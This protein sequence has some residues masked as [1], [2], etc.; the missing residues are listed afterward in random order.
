MESNPDYASS[1]TT[2]FST[3]SSGL[4]PTPHNYR[5]ISEL[6]SESWGS[7]WLT[8]FNVDQEEAQYPHQLHPPQP[9]PY[10]GKVTWSR[11]ERQ[12][13]L[14]E[15]HPVNGCC[16]SHQQSE[17]LGIQKSEGVSSHCENTLL[18]RPH[19]TSVHRVRIR[20][21]GP[22]SATSEIRTGG[23]T[24]TI[25]LLHPSRLQPHLNS[26]CPEQRSAC[27]ILHDFS[28]TSTASAPE[29]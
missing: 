3:P 13:L 10:Q 16:K 26:L 28:P 14:E 23:G 18:Q 27:C 19:A 24:T 8:Y 11:V 9:N 6:A 15:T 20:G 5:T 12:S 22:L 4:P 2:A 25:S 29:A 21:V 17:H 7:R 1:L